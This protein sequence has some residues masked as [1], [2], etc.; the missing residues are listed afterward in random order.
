MWR[1]GDTLSTP[2]EETGEKNWQ[3]IM[4][5]GN[6]KFGYRSSGILVWRYVRIPLLGLSLSPFTVDSSALAIIFCFPTVTLPH[7]SPEC[8]SGCAFFSP[9]ITSSFRASHSPGYSH[10]SHLLVGH[11]SALALA[12]GVLLCCY[13]PRLAGGML[14]KLCQLRR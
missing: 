12:G 3:K 14:C 6:A 11:P 2:R 10:R 13:L 5:L 7:E 1:E 4:T 9:C 8:H